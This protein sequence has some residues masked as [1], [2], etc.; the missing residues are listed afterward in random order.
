M[1]APRSSVWGFC[2]SFLAVLLVAESFFGTQKTA[3]VHSQQAASQSASIGVGHL[4]QLAASG[5]WDQLHHF[6][7]RYAD[8]LR[9]QEKSAAETDGSPSPATG[10]GMAK[11]N[12]EALR[13][14]GVAEYQ[15]S[16][17]RRAHLFL[18]LAVN[19]SGGFETASVDLLH[20]AGLIAL[21]LRKRVGEVSDRFIHAY[22]HTYISVYCVS[23]ACWS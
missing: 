8:W 16:D 9:L 15:R 20:D 2:R 22:I 3:F 23:V 13:I 7:A 11:A 6:G 21:T 18:E 19:A 10:A 4:R 1:R 17:I 12:V 5:E 14:F